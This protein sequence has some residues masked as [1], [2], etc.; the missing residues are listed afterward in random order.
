[1]LLF[2]VGDNA[3]FGKFAMRHCRTKTGVPG[4]SCLGEGRAAVQWRPGAADGPPDQALRPA[5]VDAA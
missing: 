5:I 2:D 3:S 4:S 1:M